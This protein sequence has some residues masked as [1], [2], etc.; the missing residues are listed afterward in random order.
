MRISDWSSDV[1]SSDL[2]GGRRG[3]VFIVDLAEVAATQV[4]AAL[5]RQGARELHELQHPA[6]HRLIPNFSS[7]SAAMRGRAAVVTAPGLPPPQQARAARASLSPSSIEEKA[8]VYQGKTANRAN[9]LPYIAI[10]ANR[11][12]A[13]RL[14]QRGLR[15]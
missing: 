13:L 9:S 15:L 2:L 1:C 4:R 12:K 8:A 5:F 11:L 10:T 6:G 7:R 3:V 14:Y